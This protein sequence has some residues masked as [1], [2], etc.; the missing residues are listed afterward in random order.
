MKNTKCERNV[1]RLSSW[2]R[3][4]C[5]WK[6]RCTSVSSTVLALWRQSKVRL[7]VREEASGKVSH[8]SHTHTGAKRE[9][10]RNLPKPATL[11]P[12]FVNPIR[13]ESL[14][15]IAV[16]FLHFFHTIAWYKALTE[17]HP[18]LSHQWWFQRLSWDL[19]S[20][21]EEHFFVPCSCPRRVKHF[22][23]FSHTRARLSSS[24]TLLSQKEQDANI[25]LFPPFPFR[26]W[27]VA[28]LPLQPLP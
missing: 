15:Q 14:S 10:R 17:H 22:L 9:E 7:Q 3:K 26:S 16:H 24:P 19:R 2:R 8:A 4:P 12:A 18:K 20:L 25:S 1:G 11:C 23:S 28:T 27:R 6:V 13:S 5:L 21:Y